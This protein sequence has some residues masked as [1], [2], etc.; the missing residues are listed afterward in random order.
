MMTLKLWS[1]YMRN[2]PAK[3]IEGRKDEEISHE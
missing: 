3:N 1:I 2:S